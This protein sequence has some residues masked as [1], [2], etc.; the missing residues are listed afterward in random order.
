MYAGGVTPEQ[1]ARRIQARRLH[2]EGMTFTAIARE[3]GVSTTTVRKYCA[4]L[5]LP[6]NMESRIGHSESVQN[7]RNSELAQ[8]PER[9]TAFTLL[10]SGMTA[11]AVAARL[12][13]D[14]R[15]VRRWVDEEVQSRIAPKVEKLRAVGNARLDKYREWAWDV[16][17][18]ATGELRLKAIDRLLQIDRRWAA[19]NGTDSPVRVEATVTEQTEADREFAELMRELEARNAV[20]EGQIVGESDVT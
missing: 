17:E 12:G 16:A 2:G 6:D 4:G 8:L 7:P 11:N 1:E 18:R 13:R 19:L 9:E 15:T 5:G 20:V 14:P 10:L 3:I